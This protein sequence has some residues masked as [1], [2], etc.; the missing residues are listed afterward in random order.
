MGRRGPLK[1]PPNV[2]ALR[3]IPRPATKN[4]DPL[5]DIPK[6]PPDLRGLALKIWRK[7]APEL[8]KLGRLALIDAPTLALYCRWVSHV[9]ALEKELAESTYLIE[10]QKG[11]QVG[12]PIFRQ[13]TT[14][15]GMVV[16][17]AKELGCTPDARIRAASI[18]VEEDELDELEAILTQPLR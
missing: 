18:P 15:T 13:L 12:N 1:L 10:G 17:L 6:P 9:D 2:S 5:P 8:F 4:I 14:A 16:K 11:N 3:G 7:T